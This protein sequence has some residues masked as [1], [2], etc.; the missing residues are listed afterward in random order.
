MSQ[1][2][3][4]PFDTSGQIDPEVIANPYPSYQELQTRDPVHWNEG[5]QA[6]TLTRYA[7]VLEVLRDQRLSVDRMSRF[8]GG[9]PEPM[10]EAMAPIIRIFS[11]MMLMSDP[12]NH[13]RLRSLA[14]KAFTPRVVEAIRA[15]IQAIVDQSLDAV[16]STGRMDVIGDLAYPLPATVIAEML[17]V[18]LED[19][20]QFKK[21]S[22]DLAMFLGDIRRAAEHVE[23][24]QRSALQM[25]DYLTGII[26]ECRQNPRDDLISALVA[27]EEQG[28][29]FSEEELFAMFVLLQV[30]GHETTTN[31]IGNGLLALLQNPEQM[32][33]LKDNPS[34][35]QTAVE[36]FVRYHS[37][38]QITSRIALEDME[39]GGKGISKGQMMSAYLGAAN[40][41]PA[42][43][44]DPE[45]LDI[46]RQENRH[47]GFG[48][49]PHFCLGAAL[50][51]LEGQIA[52]G[53]VL[54]RMP[55]LRLEPPLSGGR[56]EDFPWRQNP[57]FHGLE[58]LPVVF[59]ATTPF[60]G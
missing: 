21:W 49:G 28:D 50:A 5:L 34:L 11:N 58:S 23:V 7:D 8:G 54:R 46:T 41:D 10:Q 26:R 59:K 17:G 18:A 42:Q 2:F 16:E 13:T 36:E 37:P 15:H 44:P 56:L 12:P 20:D 27:A 6:W 45:R 51:R 43:F 30:G 55:E 33:Q 35:I 24:A 14:N 29:S 4:S 25:I 9:L 57:I 22:G 53:T 32:Q 48:F 60:R 39:L 40:R 47:V 52:I 31:L 38:V 19:R 3:T 1:E